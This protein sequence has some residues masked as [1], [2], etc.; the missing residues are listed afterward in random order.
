MKS[1]T[2]SFRSEL[3]PELFNGRSEGY[4]PGLV[5]LSIVKDCALPVHP[6][7][8]LAEIGHIC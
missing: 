6:D 3:T 4:L 1:L 8:P 7:G 2:T 5:G